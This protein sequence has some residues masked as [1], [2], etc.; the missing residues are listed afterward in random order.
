MA[1][2][3]AR[4]Q[5]F[6]RLNAEF[7]R[8]ARKDKKAEID[9]IC[10]EIDESN[11]KGKPRNMFKIIK[12]ITGTYTPKTGIIRDKAGNELYT[13]EEIKERWREY[14]EE[15]YRGDDQNW[16]AADEEEMLE[17][18]PRI[19]ESEVRWALQ[20]IA[21]GK[22]EG[23]DGLPIELLQNLQEDSIKTLTAL[24][25]E[26]W[27]TQQWPTD[28]KRSIFIP[29]PKKGKANDCTNY[30]TIALISHTSK[31]VLKIIQARLKQ[32]LNRELPEAQAGFRRGRGT[33]DHIANMRWIMEKPMN[34][35]RKYTS[36]LLIIPR[37]L[38]V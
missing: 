14:T 8:A 5:E 25:Q 17:L 13:E 2:Q 3:E 29:I 26:I 7:Q 6:A 20:N 38:T 16:A 11:T 34:S 15:L 12:Q 27:S 10:K 1:K 30:R 33:R 36:A 24:C 22:S 35:K 37:L 4:R 23:T 19:L 28:W 32:Y 9:R 31:I 21:K 18:E